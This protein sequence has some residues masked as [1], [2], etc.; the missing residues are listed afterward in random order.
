MTT[1]RTE[2]KFVFDPEINKFKLI[3]KNNDSLIYPIELSFSIENY[4]HLI[5]SAVETYEIHSGNPFPYISIYE[6]RDSQ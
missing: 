2:A 4:H 3:I 1:I 6:L 5:S